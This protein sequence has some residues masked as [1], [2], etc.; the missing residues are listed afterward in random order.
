MDN[1]SDSVDF[2][3]ASRPQ[4]AGSF[5][6]EENGKLSSS[7]LLLMVWGGGVFVIWAISSLMSQSL[8]AIPDSVIT[9][10]GICVGAKTV[11]RFGE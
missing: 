2:L 8:Q 3:A 11:Q 7:R 10:V 6:R 9:I 1:G 4:G 5:I